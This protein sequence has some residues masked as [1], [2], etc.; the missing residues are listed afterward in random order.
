MQCTGWINNSCFGSVRHAPHCAA[1][2]CCSEMMSPRAT[3]SS[4]VRLAAGA[5]L[6]AWSVDAQ[7]S[8]F[9][10]L[11]ALNGTTVERS[12][13]QTCFPEKYPHAPLFPM[14]SSDVWTLACASLGLLLAAGGGIGGG[15]ILVP[16]YVLV[17]RFAPKEAVPL[18]NITILGG[19][20]AN[21]LFN[22]WKRHPSAD[23]PLALL[24]HPRLTWRGAGRPRIDLDIVNVME[25]MTIAG[26][27]LGSLVNKL[28]PG[29]VPPCSSPSPPKGAPHDAPLGAGGS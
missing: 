15:G 24:P 17:G 6:L 16:L 5:V 4:G 22:Y 20:I 12:C 9:T 27:V 18:S 28:L 19:A 25:P 26:A 13:D 21:V 11:T 10:Q 8:L 1:P 14:H 29:C 7:P 2:S 23:R 3:P